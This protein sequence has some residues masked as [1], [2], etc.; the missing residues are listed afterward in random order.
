M[1]KLS[2]KWDYAIKAIMYLLKNKDRKVKIWEI[3]KSE[4]ISES[5]LRRVIALLEKSSIIITQKWR[6]WGLYLPSNLSNISLFDILISVGEELGVSEC[7]MWTACENILDCSATILY[8]E[9]QKGLN[10]IF[11]LYT[12]DKIEKF[13]RQ[14]K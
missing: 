13:L 3:A 5:L 7:S 2:S 9:L 6:N 1:I 12:L 11:K 4:K 8:S 10:G 14:R